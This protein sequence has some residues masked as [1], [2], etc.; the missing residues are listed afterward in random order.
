VIAECVM[1]HVCVDAETFVKTP[2]PDWLRQRLAEHR[3]R[4]LDDS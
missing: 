2:W 3:E 4:A 1:T